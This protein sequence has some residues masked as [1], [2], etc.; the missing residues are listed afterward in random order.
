MPKQSSGVGQ[1][2]L[3]YVKFVRSKGH[4][5]AYF[6]TGEK[7]FEG[8]PVYHPL[9]KFGTPSF[10]ATYGTMCGHRERRRA[11]APTVAMLIQKY[12]KSEAYRNLK[13]NSR[14]SYELT[15]RKIDHHLGKLRVEKVERA[16]IR[17][18]VNNRLTGNGTRNLF[19]NVVS[20]LY[21]W[22]RENDLAPENK[23]P[24]SG[25]RPFKTGEHEPWADELLEK[26]LACDDHRVRIAVHLLYY[27]GQRIGDVVRMQWS[28]L[29]DGSIWVKQQKTEK[30][31]LIPLHSGLKAELEKHDRTGK[32]I[33]TTVHGKPMSVSTLRNSL[34]SYA[35]DLGH[36]VVPHGLRKNAVNTLLTMGCNVDEVMAITGQ[37]R[38]MVDH[39]AKA[40]NKN[41]LGQ[42]AILKW[43][44]NGTGQTEG[45]DDEKE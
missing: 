9:P 38:Q 24:T 1:P 5:Y 16:H 37:S 36:K 33:L 42:S 25:V 3:K 4:L 22:A 14:A 45:K 13:P 29:E 20:A 8:K 44:Q 39:Y 40:I 30:T 35:A 41:R 32:T 10:Y 28:H 27:T 23:N 15:L 31:L 19:I 34:Q 2:K 43:E 26:A 11:I 18:V 21:K 12:Q 6:N 17:E 7:T